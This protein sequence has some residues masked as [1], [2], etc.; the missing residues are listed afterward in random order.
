[1]NNAYWK[2]IPI[3]LSAVKG[4][5]VVATLM[6]TY[7]AWLSKLQNLRKRVLFLLSEIDFSIYVEIEP[8]INTCFPEFFLNLIGKGNKSPTNLFFKLEN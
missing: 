1:M 5:S 7:T 8:S 3:P 2:L 4:I 6:S